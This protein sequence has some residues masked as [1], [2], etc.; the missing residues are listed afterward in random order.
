MSPAETQVDEHKRQMLRG[1]AR[2]Y[3]RAFPEAER[4]TIPV[5]FDVV[6]VYVL[7]GAPEFEFFEGAFGWR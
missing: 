7:G 2:T 3:L 4:K 5:R 1:L 6:A